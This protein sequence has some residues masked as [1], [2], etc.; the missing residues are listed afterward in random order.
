[1]MSSK[2]TQLY[3]FL[4]ISLLAGCSSLAPTPILVDELSFE[5]Q[6]F[7]LCIKNQ[8]ETYLE[9]IIRISCAEAG[10]ASVKE[11]QYMP[12]LEYIYVSS[13]DIKDIDVSKNEKLTSLIISNNKLTDIRLANN[14][15]LRFLNISNNPLT[16]LNV[17]RNTKLTR[18]Y[19]YKIPLTSINV[20]TNH[21]LQELGLSQHQL[22]DID[23]S[24]NANLGFLFLSVG[25]LTAIELNKNS[26]LH[27]LYAPANK[28][29]HLDLTNNPELVTV[30]IRNNQLK[31]LLLS[32]HSKLK[33][34]KADYNQLNNVYLNGSVN[35]EKLQINNNKI[36]KLDL[37]A[38]TQLKE[39]TAFN[40]PL[41]TLTY[42]EKQAYDVFSIEGTPVGQVME[43][44][45]IVQNE[46]LT[47][48][49]T[50]TE[51]GLITKK[52][53]QYSFNSTQALT[54]SFGDYMGFRYSVEWPE[55]AQKHLTKQSQFPITTRVTHPL[56]VDSN[57]G[58]IVTEC[59]WS[60]TMFK[61]DQNL[62][63]WHF[64]NSSAILTGRWTIEVLY[65]NSVVAKKSYWINSTSPE[66]K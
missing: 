49:V 15:S 10:I 61:H 45:S 66:R 9:N 60:D 32:E 2:I 54:P 28:I 50:V 43:S 56:M 55:I 36:N 3:T 37:S 46:K 22:T 8:G 34:L 38:Q 1:M 59:I 20:S 26:K 4:S 18:L 48:I 51:S 13:N 64:A 63:M 16:N 62:A 39:F 57:T 14:K 12:N 41:I 31:E 11:I 6:N 30:N 25:K 65:N 17:S 5:D 35:I 44:Q 33:E 40:N 52:G 24:N 47:P 23:L 19:A 53:N 7:E 42:N 27:S 58:E 29:Q 21:D